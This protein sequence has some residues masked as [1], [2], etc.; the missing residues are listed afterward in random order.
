M[1]AV[2]GVQALLAGTPENDF[3]DAVALGG[4]SLLCPHPTDAAR[5]AFRLDC[6]WN[7]AYV[8]GG[9]EASS[10]SGGDGV[11]AV[12][13]LHAPPVVGAASSSSSSSTDPSGR[14][15]L[16]RGGAWGSASSPAS[17]VVTGASSSS[18]S[19]GAAAPAATLAVVD[20]LNAGSA[21]A[22]G[23]SGNNDGNNNAGDDKEENADPAA[24][25]FPSAVHVPVPSDKAATAVAVHRASG[26][27]VVGTEDGC[28]AWFDGCL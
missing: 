22:A 2:P 25:P 9:R 16:L 12:S 8:V 15:L 7:G 27:V 1:R 28:L 14:L 10:G 24:P 4:V 20:C 13:H 3:A 21:A 19:S 26:E 23:N 5:L 11:G 6:G 17:F 18:G